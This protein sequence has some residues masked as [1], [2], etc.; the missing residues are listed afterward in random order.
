MCHGLPIHRVDKSYN[1]SARILEVQRVRRNKTPHI[2]RPAALWTSSPSPATVSI[3]E[4]GEN[5]SHD[6]GRA[7]YFE[8]RRIDDLPGH[9]ILSQ[10]VRAAAESFDHFYKPEPGAISDYMTVPSSVEELRDRVEM[11]HSV[12]LLTHVTYASIMTPLTAAARIKEVRPQ[13]V[14]AINRYVKYVQ[15]NDLRITQF[16][17]D[18]KG[19][20]S[21]KPGQQEDPMHTSMWSTSVM[22]AW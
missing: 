13:A 22:M 4:D 14:E 17:T 7:T 9:P 15:E 19:D 18:A 11:H 2:F 21:K 20:R 1:A 10:T 3:T 6:D 16:I 12:D 5:L 8:G